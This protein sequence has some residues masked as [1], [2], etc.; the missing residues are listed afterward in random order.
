MGYTGTA[1][2]EFD[3][4]ADTPVAG[5]NP[6]VLTATT[7]PLTNTK[8]AVPAL[9]LTGGQA[10]DGYLIAGGGLAAAAGLLYAIR[11]RRN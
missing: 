10:A 3:I 6:G 9:P 2:F 7:D 4:N 11:R 8:A 1:T 5:S